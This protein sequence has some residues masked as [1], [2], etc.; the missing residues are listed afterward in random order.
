M[1]R[2][3][4]VANIDGILT[5]TGDMFVASGAAT[6]ARL[7]IGS[8]GQV[9][10][11][12]GGVP[13]WATASSGGMTVLA[14]GSLTGTSVAMT[15]LPQTYKSLV[16]KLNNLSISTTN[17][18]ITLKMNNTGTG[19]VTAT[20]NSRFGGSTANLADY[21]NTY[22]ILNY[23]GLGSAYNDNFF[24]VTFLNYTSTVAPCV[25][26][27][28]GFYNDNGNY[29]NGIFGM[30]SNGDG[31]AAVTRIDIGVTSGNFDNGT[32]VLYG[33]N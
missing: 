13:S 25:C 31:G 15:S 5:T 30:G 28:T 6:P 9:L 2:A 8:T 20:T 4:D 1:T 18:N 3:R 7:G 14:S 12:A 27:I 26:Q 29:E 11:V 17:Q 19:Y 23:F 21:A 16:L 22:T 10:T 24:E 33:V 32:Y